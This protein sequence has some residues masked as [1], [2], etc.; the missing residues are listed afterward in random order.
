MLLDSL[1]VIAQCHRLFTKQLVNDAKEV[2]ELVLTL[3]SNH[4][5]DVKERASETMEAITL[6]VKALIKIVYFNCAH[7]SLQ[8]V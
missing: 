4:N 8:K 3:C 1:S 2:F 5:R 6:E 7:N